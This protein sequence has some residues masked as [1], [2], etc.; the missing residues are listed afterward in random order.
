[1][2]AKSPK[3]GE[4]QKLS[5]DDHEPKTFEVAQIIRETDELKEVIEKCEDLFK[6]QPKRRV[7]SHIAYQLKSKVTLSAMFKSQRGQ[8]MFSSK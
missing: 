7:T 1:V 3:Q 4:I 2:S 8:G 5:F 6:D